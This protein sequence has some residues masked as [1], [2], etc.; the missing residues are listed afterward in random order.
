MDFSQYFKT[1]FFWFFHAK[2]GIVV[3]TMNKFDFRNR[4]FEYIVQLANAT[5]QRPYVIIAG[6]Q[7]CPN[8]K[9]CLMLH[10]CKLGI[11]KLYY[12][13]KDNKK[14]KSFIYGQIAD[15]YAPNS[16]EI[17]VVDTNANEYPIMQVFFTKQ[18]AETNLKRHNA[19]FDVFSDYSC[20]NARA[21]ANSKVVIGATMRNETTL[22]IL[23]TLDTAMEHLQIGIELYAGNMFVSPI[24]LRRTPEFVERFEAANVHCFTQGE[25]QALTAK[26]LHEHRLKLAINDTG[27]NQSKNQASESPITANQSIFSQQQDYNDNLFEQANEALTPTTA[28]LQ[29]IQYSN[30]GMRSQHERMPANTQVLFSAFRTKQPLQKECVILRYGDGSAMYGNFTL[31]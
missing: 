13:D 11:T 19:G 16:D 9:S 30:C 7:P 24:E 12:A 21:N 14:V 17:M 27:F 29:E 31:N 10:S 22:D 6:S 26:R 4:Q 25:L 28:Y 20:N 8:Q 2:L 1:R 5:P 15:L 23:P 18:Q 3:G